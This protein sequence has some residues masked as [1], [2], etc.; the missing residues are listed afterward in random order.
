MT[1]CIA[2]PVRG[3]GTPKTLEGGM[4]GAKRTTASAG[5]L[6]APPRSGMRRPRSGDTCARRWS[7]GIRS[8]NALLQ[9]DGTV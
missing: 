2:S 4:S 7:N 9:S 1:G 8:S 6:G 3:E 5:D